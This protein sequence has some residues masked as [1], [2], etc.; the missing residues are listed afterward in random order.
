MLCGR[1]SL[2]RVGQALRRL[3]DDLLRQP[4]VRR[5]D[6]AH[7]IQRGRS[8]AAG[9]PDYAAAAYAYAYAY[10]ADPMMSVVVLLLLRGLL[11][12]LLLMQV[13]RFLRRR[14]LVEERETAV[15]PIALQHV[16][17]VYL[18]TLFTSIDW[19]RPVPALA[20]P[21]EADRGRGRTRNK[22]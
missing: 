12:L 5:R 16:D 21:G 18:F 17:G 6:P 19:Q 9:F 8:A 2:L 22:G 10:A 14:F 7:D 4:V 1:G 15:S 13:H 3:H 20:R 11:R